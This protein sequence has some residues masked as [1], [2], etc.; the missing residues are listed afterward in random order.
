MVE[1]EMSKESMI[2]AQQKQFADRKMGVTLEQA[3]AAGKQKE[4]NDMMSEAIKGPFH[5]LFEKKKEIKEIKGKLESKIGDMFKGISK[6]KEIRGKLDQEVAKKFS[7]KKDKNEDINEQV[8][9]P[10]KKIFEI[11]DKDNEI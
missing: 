10:E 9:I 2:K 7:E 3:I 8:D 5:K 4:I 6:K 1:K 11:G